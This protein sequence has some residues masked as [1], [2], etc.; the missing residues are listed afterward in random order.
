MLV[1]F[2][3]EFL[4]KKKKSTSIYMPLGMVIL[5]HNIESILRKERQLD[6]AVDT[7]AK[8]IAK[9]DKSVTLRLPSRELHLISK[10]NETL[11]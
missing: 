4:L 5:I 7:V 9:N 10:N 3:K 1:W 2:G 8:L 11:Y 6:R